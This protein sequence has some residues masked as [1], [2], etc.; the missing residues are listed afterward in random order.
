MR[1][2]QHARVSLAL[3]ELQPAQGL[4][5]LLL[6]ALGG[7][8]EDFRAAPP[9]WPG[10]VYALDFCGHGRSGR[11]HGSGYYPELWAADADL[12]L[13]AIGDDAV[14]MGVGLGAYVALLLAGGRPAQVRCAVLGPGAGLEG[15]GD[16]PGFGRPVHDLAT[17]PPARELQALASTDPGVFV[18]QDVYSRPPS[19]AAGY[20]AAARRIVLLEDG[21]ERPGWWRAAR[22]AQGARSCPVESAWPQLAL[23]GFAPT[24]T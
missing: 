16:E 6:H 8:A 17:S 5:L 18:G 19:Y 7:S 3:H 9:V 4:P 20:A 2:L 13:A 11:V 1:T 24:Q 21:A 14:L 12:A 15:G 22:E 10:P 23:A